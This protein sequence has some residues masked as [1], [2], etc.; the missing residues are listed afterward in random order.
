[1]IAVAA[2]AAAPALATHGILLVSDQ[3]DGVKEPQEFDSFYEDA[4]R[5]ALAATTDE[6]EV[7]W[8]LRTVDD[9]TY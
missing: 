6:L 4:L 7:D 1:M 3:V 2:L 5:D 8:T 9:V